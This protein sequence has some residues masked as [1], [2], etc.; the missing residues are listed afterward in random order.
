MK[1]TIQVGMMT[2]MIQSM[3]KMERIFL[4][5]VYD[6]INLNMIKL[7][8]YSNLRIA[9]RQT[10]KVVLIAKSQNNYNFGK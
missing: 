10:I 3:V 9:D 4:R 7:T 8:I 2:M 5:I 6:Q 1:E